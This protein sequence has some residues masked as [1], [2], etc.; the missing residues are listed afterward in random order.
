MRESHPHL[1]GQN[2]ARYFYA[3]RDQKVAEDRGLAPQRL[4]TAH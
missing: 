4:I 2:L 1:Q 3:N